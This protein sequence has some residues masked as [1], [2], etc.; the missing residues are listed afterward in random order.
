MVTGF[1]RNFVL[2]KNVLVFKL[3]CPLD[4]TIGKV[5]YLNVLNIKSKI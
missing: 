1:K 4:I 2:T 5:I 3:I